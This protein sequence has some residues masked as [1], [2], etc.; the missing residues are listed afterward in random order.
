ME[1]AS[2]RSLI[3]DRVSFRYANRISRC[4]LVWPWAAAPRVWVQPGQRHGVSSRRGAGGATRPLA[5]RYDRNSNGHH[6]VVA[7]ATSVG[8]TVGSPDD[9]GAVHQVLDGTMLDLDVSADFLR[10]VTVAGAIVDYDV[11]VGGGYAEGVIILRCAFAA[12]RRGRGLLLD[13]RGVHLATQDARTSRLAWTA[14]ATL[15]SWITD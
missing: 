2:A 13:L 3:Y 1:A 11:T 4:S 14:A 15:E 12:V 5:L 8:V 6:H 7:D 10:G 9:V